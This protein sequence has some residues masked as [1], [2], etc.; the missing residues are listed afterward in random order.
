ML[1]KEIKKIAKFK[2]KSLLFPSKSRLHTSIGPLHDLVTRY[3]INHAERQ[4]TQ[5]DFQNIGKSGWAGTSFFVLEVP[6][7]YLRPS[8][9]FSVQCDRIVQGAYFDRCPRGGGLRP[10]N[11]SNLHVFFPH[12]DIRSLR[13]GKCLMSRY[14]FL[15][16]T[17]MS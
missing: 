2:K 11:P 16:M 14:M 9:I 8:L 1:I 4:T 15:L 12:S 10:E 17:F 13:P 5:R 3:G 6:P 7:R